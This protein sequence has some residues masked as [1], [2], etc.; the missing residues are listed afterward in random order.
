[1]FCE[2]CCLVTLVMCTSP[3]EIQLG[4]PKLFSSRGWPDSTCS[5]NTRLHLHNHLIGQ[6]TWCVSTALRI[7]QG[8]HSP[9][10]SARPVQTCYS[11][12]LH[13]PSYSARPVQ[14][15][16]SVG[17]AQSCVECR[18]HKALRIVHGLYSPAYSAGSAKP[19]VTYLL[20]W[21]AGSKPKQS[22]LSAAV[23][24]CT[25]EPIRGELAVKDTRHT[26]LL[27]LAEGELVV[28][29]LSPNL[30]TLKLKLLFLILMASQLVAEKHIPF[31][32]ESLLKWSS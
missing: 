22:E 30:N 24:C 17:T 3:Q 31:M 14:T 7:L 25:H 8:L 29:R 28:I 6:Y 23:H 19:Y 27:I 16:Y 12:E 9:T 18:A 15:C 5:S 21:L 32:Q 10:Y 1:M 26:P 2:Q 20:I 13:S 11:V 4:V